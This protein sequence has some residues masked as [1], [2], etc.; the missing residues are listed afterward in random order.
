[1][2]RHQEK[3]NMVLPGPLNS[4]SRQRILKALTADAEAQSFVE[5]NCSSHYLNGKLIHFEGIMVRY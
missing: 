2:L 4:G 5:F 3:V 1:M